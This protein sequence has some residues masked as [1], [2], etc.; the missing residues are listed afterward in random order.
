MIL[1]DII[2]LINKIICLK[3]N[4]SYWTATK[5][6]SLSDGKKL[7][8]TLNSI[9]S[10]KYDFSLV[11]EWE[12]TK[13][14]FVIPETRIIQLFFSRIQTVLLDS[15]DCILIPSKVDSMNF[16]NNLNQETEQDRDYHI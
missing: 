9:I 6:E 5:P 14:L 8:K 15:F 11:T 2:L 7:R 12:H 3:I 1:I 13:Y 10:S 4:F 16:I